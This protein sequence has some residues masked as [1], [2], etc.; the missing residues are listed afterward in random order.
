MVA[1][2]DLGI[3]VPI[4]KL[5]IYQKEIVTKCRLKGK[6]VITATHL[7]ETMIDNP[8]PT[9]AESSDVFN[10]VIQKAD[11]LMLSGETTIG[12]FPIESV[13]MM[14]SIIQEAEKIVKY[15]FKDFE[16]V[17][18]NS[19]DIEKKYLIRSGLFVGRDL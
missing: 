16:N 1:R 18:L 14:T 6:F 12:K 4:S 17:D 19:R 10:A 13:Q 8:F 3:E 11:A 2:G 5:A 15:D 7:L 9:R